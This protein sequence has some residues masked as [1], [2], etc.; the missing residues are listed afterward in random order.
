[1]ILIKS[2]HWEFRDLVLSV[3]HPHNPSKASQGQ[4]QKFKNLHFNKQTEFA[5]TYFELK[6]LASIILKHVYH[7]LNPIFC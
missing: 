2:F 7:L 1:M 5:S 6:I 3:N 4:S